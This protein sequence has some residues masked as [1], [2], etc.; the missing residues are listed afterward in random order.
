MGLRSIQDIAPMYSKLMCW[1]AQTIASDIEYLLSLHSRCLKVVDSNN[2][3]ENLWLDHGP[4]TWS[5]G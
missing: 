1:M 5:N 3:H 2:L 4:P